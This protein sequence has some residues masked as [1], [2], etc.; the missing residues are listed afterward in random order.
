MTMASANYSSIRYHDTEVGVGVIF[1]NAMQSH[2]TPY[3]LE[4]ESSCVDGRFV[5]RSKL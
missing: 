1:V 5:V 3:L 4:S 2:F